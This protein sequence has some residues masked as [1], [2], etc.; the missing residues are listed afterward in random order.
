M[1]V[2]NLLTTGEAAQL[3]NISRSTISRKFD[4]GVFGGKKNP[5]TGERMVS[6]ESLEVFAKQYNLQLDSLM[7]GKRV[8]VG[9]SDENLF[10]MLQSS[11]AEDTRIQMERVPFGGDVLVA[12]SKERPDLLILDEELSDIACTEIIRSLRRLEELKDL[13]ILV[14]AKSRAT[15]RY[16]EWGVGEVLAKEDFDPGDTARSLYAHLEIT[17][18]PAE[19][20]RSFEHQRR[21]PRIPINLPAKLSVYRVST[22]YHREVGEATVEN[23]SMGGSFLSGIKFEKGSLPSE[24]FRFLLEIDHPPLKSWRAHC[25]VVRLQSNGSVVAGVQYVRLSKA[26]RR[27]IE[28]MAHYT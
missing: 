27:M 16:A 5:I 8:L 4:R 23:I 7:M 15:K 18:G 6:R 3:L 28:S 2:K 25:K 13:K 17:P 22:P 11:M 20:D 19:G 1:E 21:W 24:P 14:F 26:N 12:S 9:T 10:A